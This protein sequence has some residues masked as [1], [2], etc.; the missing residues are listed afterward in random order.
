MPN[1]KISFREFSDYTELNEEQLQ[2][3]FSKLAPELAAK[4]KSFVGQSKANV[5]ARDNDRKEREAFNKAAAEKRLALQANNAAAA[6]KAIDDKKR[7]KNMSDAEKVRLAQKVASAPKRSDR[8]MAA[9]ER[10]AEYGKFKYESVDEVLTDLVNDEI[11]IQEISVLEN[12]F[13]KRATRIIERLQME[14]EDEEEL[15]VALQ[16]EINS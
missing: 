15:F 7:E 2:E 5:D 14:C 6:K 3:I 8:A 9:D 1:K 13:A 4:V 10:G 12:V 11:T 16:E